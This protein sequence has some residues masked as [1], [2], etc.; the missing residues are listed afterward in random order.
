MRRRRRRRRRPHGEPTPAESTR[1]I[2]A[3]RWD[4]RAAGRDIFALRRALNRGF[5]RRLAQ[6][7]RRRLGDGSVAILSPPRAPTASA[8]SAAPEACV[9]CFGALLRRD[10]TALREPCIR[11]A[12]QVGVA[13]STQTYR[14]RAPRQH[15]PPAPRPRSRLDKPRHGAVRCCRAY[16]GGVAGARCLARALLEGGAHGADCTASPPEP[17]ARPHT[18]ARRSSRERNYRE[19]KFRERKFREREFRERKFRRCPLSRAPR[20]RL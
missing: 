17:T 10:G 6:S 4:W 9:T 2:R 3:L 1:R 19:R 7:S 12:V 20:C 18:S 11:Q 14:R 16:L 13:W 15:R 5:K 8:P